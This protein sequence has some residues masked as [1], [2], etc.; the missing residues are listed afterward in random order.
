M[1]PREL[2]GGLSTEWD[3]GLDPSPYPGGTTTVEA[4]WMG[5][6]VLTRRRALPVAPWAS[7]C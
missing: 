7:A 6:P 5:V 2:S 3:I 1:P 4:L